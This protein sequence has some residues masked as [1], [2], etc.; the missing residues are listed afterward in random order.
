[1]FAAGITITHWVHQAKS[2]HADIYYVFCLV[3]SPFAETSDL[4]LIAASASH[5]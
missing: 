5:A 4:Y 2:T 1:M 3:V